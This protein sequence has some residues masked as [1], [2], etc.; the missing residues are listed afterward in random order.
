MKLLS[1]IQDIIQ[2]AE[3]NLYNASLQNSDITEIERLQ[4]KLD[5]SFK[6]LEIYKN[7]K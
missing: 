7:L 4:E 6:L 3:D 2:E 1:T 5:D